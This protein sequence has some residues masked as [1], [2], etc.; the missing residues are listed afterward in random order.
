VINDTIK[1]L[2]IMY[3]YQLQYIFDS[4]DFYE[5]MKPSMRKI[6]SFECLKNYY[7]R[8]KEFFHNPEL[9]FQAPDKFIMKCLFA[10]EYK[11]FPPGVE[12]ISRGERTNDVYFVG[13]GT[14]L[15]R[16]YFDEKPIME[17]PQYSFFGDYQVLLDVRS[18]L[19][20]YAGEEGDVVLFALGS[21]KFMKLLDEYSGDNW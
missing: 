20:F 13:K 19:T 4:E 16:D 1:Y 7:I 18:N 3:K 15:I 10:F 17:V 2:D 9:Q 14:V 21:D 8:Y 11:I 6:L 5:Q 12:I